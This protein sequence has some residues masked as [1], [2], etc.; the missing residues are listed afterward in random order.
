MTRTV[1]F[2][3]G[4]GVRAADYRRS[5]LRVQAGVAAAWPTARVEP[6]LWGDKAGARLARKGVSIPDFSG[7]PAPTD[8][9]AALAVLW[10]LLS[11]DPD[12]EWRELSGATPASGFVDAGLRT[13]LANFPQRIAALGSLRAALDL[14]PA[15]DDAAARAAEW[16]RACQQ[17]A[18][19]AELKTALAGVKRVDG[20]VRLAA[21][22]ACVARWQWQRAFAPGGALIAATRDDVVAALF[23]E[24]GGADAGRVS[25]WITARFKGA[26]L[27]WATDKARR[28]RDVLYNAAYPAAGDILLYQARGEAIREQIASR[29]D[30]CGDEVIVLAHS[31][32]GIACVD[33]LVKHPRPQVKA[34]VTCG[35]QAP[36]LY[37]LG[38]L[39]S[40]QPDEA[41]PDSF[42]KTW[43]NF[44][45]RDDLLSYLAAPLFK[46]VARDVE[47]RSGVPFPD[48]HSAYWS[49]PLMWQRLQALIP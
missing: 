44:F 5:L 17:V 43:I 7:E 33:L 18:G 27:R 12:Y 41:L 36:L 42:P 28:E 49:Q 32:G 39:V 38:A 10:E 47:V 16:S 29:I 24:L 35:S 25:D 31:L 6:C 2:V 20:R 30:A 8:E 15:D 46:P 9:A 37:E 13:A 19:S 26:L 40:L 21:A 48:S 14:L 23:A 22:R 4:T 3:H 45:D 11:V 34:L 1:L